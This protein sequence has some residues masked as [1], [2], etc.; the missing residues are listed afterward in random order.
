MAKANY[1]TGDVVS[2]VRR[3]FRENAGAYRGT[4]VFAIVC[5]LII[6]V[7]T[8][9]TAWIMRDVIDEIFVRQQRDLI[10][11][12]AGAFAASF[13]IR[14][15]A[16]YYQAMA[17]GRIG[18][19]LVA[20]YQQR[21][22]DQL[23]KLGLNYYADNR[24]GALAGQISY[25]VYGIRDLISVT[26]TTF[27]RDIVTLIGLVIVMVLQDPVLSIAALLIGPPLAL[28]VNYIRRRVRQ[29]SLQ[30]IQVNAHL[31]GAMQEATQGIAVVKAYTMED[32][33]A[34]K[35]EKLVVEAE[36]R[37]NK[38]ISVTERLAPVTEILAGLAVAGIIIYAGYRAAV[39]AYPPGAIFSF[40]TAFFL[41]YDP[42]RRLSRLQVNIERAMVNAQM[43]YDILDI[44]PRQADKP[45]AKPLV[46]DKGEIRFDNV[47]FGYADNSPVLT[48]LSFVAEAGKTTAIVGASG[49]GKSTIVNLLE[50]F[51]DVGSG[52]IQVDGQDI[53]DVTKQ[54]LRSSIAYVSQQP[55]LFEGTIR[56]NI[57]YARPGATDGEVEAAAALAAA[58]EFIRAQPQ[59]YE[60]PVGENGASLSGGQRQRISIARAILRDAPILV[61][62]EAT[63]ALDN[64]SEA[65]VQQALEQAMK[66]RTAI[67]IAH[68]LS[69]IVNA[70]NIIVMEAG[71]IIEQ[72]S[73]AGLL[74]IANG[75]YK[76]FYSLQDHR[77][78]NAAPA[79]VASVVPRK[80]SRSKA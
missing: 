53:V 73:H 40:I 68:R 37:S 70:D 36:G 44:E 7:T 65:R 72:G 19:N 3:I 30:S 52:T 48:D 29:I 66:G 20:R 47:T 1:N 49:S 11:P 16:S 22:F 25:N 33:L 4:Y 45:G 61:L 71:R 56:D 35:I 21:I 6:S 15:M 78:L 26:L 2:L 76:R 43:I 31:I 57:R 58:D 38:I 51:Y 13:I 74:K 32:Q 54:S 46:I 28:S 75:A 42:V 39:E 8:A 62:D 18:N 10:Y 17:L 34:A 14:G 67:V 69:T 12:I 27:A 79:P 59:G 23:M 64:E 77:G 55:Y 63:S 41:A 5:L 80:R 50:R 24:S 60:T 9:F